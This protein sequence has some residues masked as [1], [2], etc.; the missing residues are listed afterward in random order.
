MGG[1]IG[2]RLLEE[3]DHVRLDRVSDRSKLVGYATKLELW[4]T[5]PKLCIAIQKATRG[6]GR[7]LHIPSLDRIISAVPRPLGLPNAISPVQTQ[8]AERIYG[9]VIDITGVTTASGKTHIL[10]YVAMLSSL[11]AS[12][13]GVALDGKSAAV[14]I[15]DSDGRFDVRRLRTMIKAHLQRCIQISSDSIEDN[16]V[17]AT[18]LESLKHIHIYKPQST[19]DMITMLRSLPEYLLNA[20]GHY[21]GGRR[22]DAI[23]VDG[24][25]AFYWQDRHAGSMP[26]AIPG[27][28]ETYSTLVGLLREISSR[29]GAFI[30][31][32]N[33]GLQLVDSFT[34]GL[35]SVSG[36]PLARGSQQPAFRSHLP[37]SWWKFVD[38][39]FVVQRDVATPFRRDITVVEAVAAKTTRPDVSGSYSFSGWMDVRRPRANQPEPQKSKEWGFRYWIDKHGISFEESE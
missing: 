35:D 28:Q 37:P 32:S 27:Y 30:L 15:F 3:V 19:A 8:Q 1:E 31:A 29:F 4:L 20:D 33:W 21:S 9:P 5:K 2:A 13:R 6:Q 7:P 22:L 34:N 16:A 14:V 25:S 11:P 12:L 24:M 23:L 26:T 18:A 38:I 39:R 17:E 36:L 10:Y